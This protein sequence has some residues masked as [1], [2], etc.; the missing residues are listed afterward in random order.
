MQTLAELNN[1]STIT[2]PV[3]FVMACRKF[4][5]LKLGQTLQEFAAE[6]RALTPDDKNDLIAM[7]KDVGIDAS[8]VA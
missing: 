8:K 6:L 5:G 2:G 4:F 7:F 3:T 1:T